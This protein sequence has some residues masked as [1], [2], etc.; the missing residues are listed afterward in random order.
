MHNKQVLTIILIS[1]LLVGATITAYT[2]GTFSVTNGKWDQK[3][4]VGK[5]TYTDAS[6]NSKVVIDSSDFDT[7]ASQINNAN[8]K[9]DNI[10]TSIGVEGGG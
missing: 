10:L 2:A 9:V 6:T 4:S 5:I 7:L 8:T 1:C 3:K